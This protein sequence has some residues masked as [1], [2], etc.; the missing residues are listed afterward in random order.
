MKTIPATCKKCGLIKISGSFCES[1]K[2][3][4]IVPVGICPTMRSLKI[5][6]TKYNG[7]P[8]ERSTGNKIEDSFEKQMLEL[9][10]SNPDD[11]DYENWEE[12]KLRPLEC[13]REIL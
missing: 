12:H 4:F 13:W 3:G 10:H 2:E 11:G 9:N 6:Y 5:F 1:D 8:Y 7:E